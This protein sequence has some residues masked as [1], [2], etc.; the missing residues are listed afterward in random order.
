MGNP[1]HEILKVSESE[2][3]DLIAMASHG[4][5]LFADLFFGSTIAKVRHDTPIPILVVKGG[6][7]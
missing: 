4:H 1:P 5:K 2:K 7:P 3:C 6:K